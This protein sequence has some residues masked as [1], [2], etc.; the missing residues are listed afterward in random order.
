MYYTYL[1]EMKAIK[2]KRTCCLLLLFL[3]RSENAPTALERFD[4][5][6]RFAK[7][8]RILDGVERALE[9]GP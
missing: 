6:A 5:S 2:G 1:I 7:L 9:T 3:F 8:E 4:Y